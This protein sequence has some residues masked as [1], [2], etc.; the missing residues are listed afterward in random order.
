MELFRK[1]RL[2][3][4]N[5]IL[6]KKVGRL[7]RKV[8]YSGF[9]KVRSIGI[10][11]DASSISDFT[12]LSRFHQKMND[13][14]IEVKVFGYFPGKELPD[15][16][17]AIRFLSC[18]KRDELTFFYLP[19][20]READNFC[21]TNFDVLIDM[22]YGSELPLSYIT[23]QSLASFRVGLSGSYNGP[24]TFD[25]MMEIKKPVQTESYLNEIIHYLEMI[26]S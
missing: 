19:V 15:Q 6:L 10:V 5:S 16:Y 24:D 12:S 3:I 17:T 2:K 1:T 21:R 4:G 13:R 14:G 26:K 23:S 7:R 11:W 9:D 22:N 8:S 18:I 20:S 25:L